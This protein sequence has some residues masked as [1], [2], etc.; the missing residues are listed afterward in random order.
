MEERVM[1]EARDTLFLGRGERKEKVGD[2]RRNI[3]LLEGCEL[4][5]S[6]ICQE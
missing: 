3:T 2:G 4:R 5:S 1:G 6:V